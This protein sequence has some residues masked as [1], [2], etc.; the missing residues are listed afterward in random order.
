MKRYYTLNTGNHQHCSIISLASNET[1][2]E[3]P[4]HKLTCHPHLEF[5]VT[6]NKQKDVSGRITTTNPANRSLTA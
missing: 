1:K 3:K 5:L 2:A 6:D 4:S